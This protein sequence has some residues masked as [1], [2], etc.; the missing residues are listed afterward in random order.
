[1]KDVRHT[2]QLL[3]C[4]QLWGLEVWNWSSSPFRKRKTVVIHQRLWMRAFSPVSV[5]LPLALLLATAYWEGQP[6][7]CETNL[8]VPTLSQAVGQKIIVLTVRICW[9]EVRLR[10]QFF[11]PALAF[12]FNTHWN[13]G[14]DSVLWSRKPKLYVI[15]LKRISTLK[16]FT[17]LLYFREGRDCAVFL[18]VKW[19]KNSSSGGGVG[20]GVVCCNTHCFFLL[21]ATFSDE[22]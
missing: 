16:R 7:C 14:I 18:F 22:T 17:Y 1:M 20:Q 5:H 13:H 19:V 6:I 4:K 10:M 12:C 21:W 9:L 11:S 3:H 15:W 2:T 8:Y